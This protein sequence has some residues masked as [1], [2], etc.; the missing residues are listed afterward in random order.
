MFDY[1]QEEERKQN[2]KNRNFL[3]RFFV[4]SERAV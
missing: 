4:L 1:Y 2:Q 3:K